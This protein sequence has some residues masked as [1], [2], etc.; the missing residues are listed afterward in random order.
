M[1]AFRLQ[2]RRE[3]RD[4]RG[5]MKVKKMALELGVISEIVEGNEKNCYVFVVL[6]YI[7]CCFVCGAPFSLWSP[8]VLEWLTIC[9]VLTLTVMLNAWKVLQWKH[10]F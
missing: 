10:D 4:Y 3:I 6:H 9:L 2:R 8:I 7:C 1:L 5:N